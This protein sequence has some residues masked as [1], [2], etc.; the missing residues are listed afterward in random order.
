MSEVKTLFRYCPAC[1]KRFHIRLVNKKLVRDEEVTSTRKEVALS[2]RTLGPYTPISPAMLEADVPI[3]IEVED[4]DY[5]YKCKHC[6][7][8][9]TEMRRQ[10][11]EIK[12]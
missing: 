9:W 4:F 2:G 3:T 12:K 8:F 1:G 10:E 7:H 5:S 11:K 6:G